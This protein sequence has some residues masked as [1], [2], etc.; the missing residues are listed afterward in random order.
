MRVLVTGGAGFIGSH[1]VDRLLA[2]GHEVRS[3]TRSTRRCTTAGA[4]LP[5]AEARARRRRRPR[6]RRRRPRASTAST[7]SCISPRRSASASRCTRSSATVG[8]RARRGRRARGRDRRARP[9]EKARRR[10]V[11]VDLRRGPLPLPRRGTRGRAGAR[12][13]RAARAPRVGAALPGLRRA[14]RAARRRR[15]T[16]PLAAASVYAIKKRDHE[17]LFLAWGRAYGVPAT[18]LRFFNVYGPRQALSN[19]YTG[20][21]RSSPRACSTAGRRWSSRTAA[22]AATSSTSPTSSPGSWPRSSRTRRRRRAQPR[23]RPAVTVLDVAD[24]LARGLGVDIEPE[25]RGEYRAGDIRHCF[26]SIAGPGELLGFEPD[27]RRSRTAWR[28]L[29]GWLAGAGRGRPGRRGD[30]ALSRS[31]GLAR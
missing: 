4:G 21:A 24:A 2:A 19:P 22:R 12:A 15:E 13:E 8:E 20:V 18:A 6:P 28:E 11:D 7:R 30:R 31:R 26:G 17:E 10:L 1:L 29:V 27:G 23:H 16:K 14:A 9:A 5:G 25:V 3:S